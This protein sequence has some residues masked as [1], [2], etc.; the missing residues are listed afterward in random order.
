MCCISGHCS[1]APVPRDCLIFYVHAY[2][3]A[4][5]QNSPI[6]KACL[7]LR[8]RRHDVV[9]SLSRRKIHLLPQVG[10]LEI[11]LSSPLEVVRARSGWSDRPGVR[12]LAVFDQAAALAPLTS[13]VAGPFLHR[14][15]SGFGSHGGLF[16]LHSRSKDT[17][18]G[19]DRA[20][21]SVGSYL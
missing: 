8:A 16:V 5:R 7:V 21:F 2:S 19:S 18:R 11:F 1:G 13:S 10:H 14:R 6:R 3:S 4:A 12:R 15:C 17:L 20:G 9:Y